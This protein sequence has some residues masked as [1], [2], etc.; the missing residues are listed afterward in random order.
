MTNAFAQAL[1]VSPEEPGGAAGAPRARGRLAPQASQTLAAIA[2]S[3]VHPKKGTAA[4][5]LSQFLPQHDYRNHGTQ[6]AVA[7]MPLATASPGG[8]CRGR[9]AGRRPEQATQTF[10]DAIHPCNSHLAKRRSSASC[11]LCGTLTRSFRK[12]SEQSSLAS[13]CAKLDKNVRMLQDP[14]IP[15]IY[16]TCTLEDP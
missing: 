5:R 4:G 8:S 9:A 2:L 15:R 11:T 13:C 6:R 10:Q 12:W 14:C 16:P 7:T 1:A 3:K